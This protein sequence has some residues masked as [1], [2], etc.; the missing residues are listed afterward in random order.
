MA[1]STD[2]PA[3]RTLSRP[4][5][6]RRLP[7]KDAWCLLLYLTVTIATGFADLRMRPHTLNVVK[8]Y[9]PGVVANT[10]FAPGKYRVLTPF[11]VDRVAQLFDASLLNTWY[12]TRLLWILAAYCL[13]HAYLRT[14]FPAE[15]ALAGVALTAATLPLTF[16]NSWPHPDSMAELALFTL[17]ALA[18]ARRAD[19][20]FA[21]A[22]AAAAFNR[23]TSVFLVL[24]FVVAEP[25]T[26][27]RCVKAVLFAIEWFAIYAGL[28]LARGLEHYDYWQAAR[29]LSDLGLLP[30]NY[31]PYYRAYAY[32]GLVLFG[33]LL[34]LAVKAAWAPPFVRRALL[35]VPCFVAVAFVFSNIIETRIF[36]PLYP[37]VL[38]ALM[39]TLFTTRNDLNQFPASRSTISG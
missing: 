17:A 4:H 33:P 32:F 26:R 25:L 27:A 29:N 2:P 28:R 24:L 5:V 37:L 10:E 38:P 11:I 14:W 12:V 20:V 21:A 30:P 23:E 6:R 22:L 19:L 15:A 8:S 13:L 18:V 39:F 34:F 7:A 35:V 9:I 3:A 1:D 31:D 36:T 16:T